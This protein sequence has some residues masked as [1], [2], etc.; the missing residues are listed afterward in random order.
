MASLNKVILIGNLT[1]DP[2][3]KFLPN[4]TAVC[5]FGLAMNRKFKASDGTQRDEATFVDCTI[6]GK[7][8]EVFNQYM[9]KG[10][11]CSIDGRLKFESWE[12]KQNGGK[13]SKLSVVVEDFQ[14]LGTG[15]GGDEDQTRTQQRPAA[16][17]PARTQP[18]QAPQAPYTDE[19]HFDDDS[20]PF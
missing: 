11:L 20:I 13:R 10:K 12:D 14:F 8:A 15:G 3:L 17:P 1:R 5:T 16:Q 4:Q 9:S 19:Q 6:F 7:G 18:A 2:E